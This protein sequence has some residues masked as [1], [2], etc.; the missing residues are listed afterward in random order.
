MQGGAVD[1]GNGLE[2]LRGVETGLNHNG[3]PI[4][5]I[6]DMTATTMII[7]D[8]GCT[9]I[10]SPL[11]IRVSPMGKVNGSESYY[12]ECMFQICNRVPAYGY[13]LTNKS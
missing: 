13:K 10:H 2:G 5:A 11:N 6:R 9:E 1:G 4:Y 7:G 12:L 8:S 3:V